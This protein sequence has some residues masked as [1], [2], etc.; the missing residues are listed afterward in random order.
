MA[1]A[2]TP[3]YCLDEEEL[4]SLRSLVGDDADDTARGLGR[5]PG[6]EAFVE[7]LRKQAA[8]ADARCAD[9]QDVAAA[10]RRVQE[11]N[12]RRLA[13]KEHLVDPE[14]P[15][16]LGFVANE[17]D[18]S[19]E[20]GDLPTAEELAVAVEVEDA[21]V[22]MEERM[23]RLA[24]RLRRGAAAFA[25]RPGEEALVAALQR[26]AA[27]ADAARATVEAFI[28]S[29]RRFRAAGRSIPDGPGGGHARMSSI[30]LILNVFISS[31]RNY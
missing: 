4:C 25:A 28:A 5:R 8:Y 21:A 19:L 11:K 9:A 12:L 13:A 10:T 14:M 29:V 1:A 31:P 2:I 18:S 15:G 23:G 26:Q 24:G 27:N 7:A 3:A 6:E 20:R 16:F 30:Y 17:T 22:R